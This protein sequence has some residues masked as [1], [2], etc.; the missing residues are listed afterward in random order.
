MFRAG[1]LSLFALIAA[2]FA[3][4]LV[5]RTGSVSKPETPAAEAAVPIIPATRSPMTAADWREKIARTPASGWAGLMR[6][7]LALA[8]EELR[9]ELATTLVAEWISR[10][11]DGYL[12]FLDAQLVEEGLSSESMRRFSVVIIRGFETTSGK[13][14]LQGKMRY[15]A[16]AITSYMIANNLVGAE[17]WVREFLVGLD[18]DIALAKIAPAMVAKSPEKAQAIFAGIKSS[19]APPQWCCRTWHRASEARS[20][21]R[22]AVG[23]FARRPQ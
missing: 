17:S 7:L 19:D 16:E 3:L 6:G 20:G 4:L 10:D 14:E 15:V 22:I 5:S 13:T 23:E 12:T 8:D 18:M 2:V 1:I 11:L 9:N 21:H